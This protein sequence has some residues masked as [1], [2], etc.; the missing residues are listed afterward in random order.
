MKQLLVPVLFLV[1]MQQVNAQKKYLPSERIYDISYGSFP[2]SQLDLYLPVNRTKETPF[3]IVIHGGGWVAG[4]KKGDR[5]SQQ[6]L[7]EQGIASANINYRFVDSLNTHY[8][9]MLADIDSAVNFC[10]ANAAKWQ[11]RP[12]NFVF[13]GASAGG[14]LALL[15]PYLY[16]RKVNSIIAECAPADLADT[17]MLHYETTNGLLNIIF[18]MA[19]ATWKPGEAVDP[20]FIASSPIYHIKNIPTLIVHGTK[21]RTVP[22]AQAVKLHDKLSSMKIPNKL[23]TLQGADHDLNIKDMPTRTMIYKEIADW[24]WMYNK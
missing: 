9:A 18:K 12:E 23:I 7:M 14:H 2:S 21:D 16:N 1:C 5:G 10:I 6:I 22:F 4:D 3:V 17:A 15:Y 19:G 11:T 8:P 20:K 24:I 13:M